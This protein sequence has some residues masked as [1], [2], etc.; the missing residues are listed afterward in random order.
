MSE[1]RVD[2]PSQDPRLQVSPHYGLADW[3]GDGA[4]TVYHGEHDEPEDSPE[5]GLWSI[6]RPDQVCHYDYMV[7]RLQMS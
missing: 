2:R 5:N 7:N 6:C 1:A 4:S 3:R